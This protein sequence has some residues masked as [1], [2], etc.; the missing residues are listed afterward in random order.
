MNFSYESSLQQIDSFLSQLSVQR[1]LSDKTLSAYRYDLNQL[2]VWLHSQQLSHLSQNKILAYFEYLQKTKCLN[3]RSIQRK[4]I[5][6]HQFFE[7]MLR[8]GY[9]NEPLFYFLPA[10]FISLKD[11]PNPYQTTRYSA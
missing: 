4:Y 10:V 8:M 2:F 3:P 1:N 11:Y 6:I 5:S 9:L 7:F